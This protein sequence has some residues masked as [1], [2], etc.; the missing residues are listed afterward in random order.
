MVGRSVACVAVA[1]G[2]QGNARDSATAPSTVA[3]VRTDLPCKPQ[4]HAY[5]RR[6]EPLFEG[7]RFIAGSRDGRRVALMATHMG[8]GSGQPVGGV[9]V[10]EAGSAKEVLGKSYFRVTGTEDDLPKV[11]QGI[12]ADYASDLSAVGVEVGNHLPVQ[13]AWCADGAGRLHLGGGSELALHVTRTPCPDDPKHQAIAWQVCSK[14]GARC[15]RGGP[16][17][18]IDG[19]VTVTD[20]YRLGEVDWVVVDVAMQPFSGADFHLFQAAGGALTGS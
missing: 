11:E 2:C 7:Y 18:C 5:A 3:P 6:G 15:A 20:F 8:P 19:S 17:G 1:L 16:S 10:L 12:V 9:H 4:L 14:D 13:Q